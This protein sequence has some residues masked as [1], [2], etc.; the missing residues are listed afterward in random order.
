MFACTKQQGTCIRDTGEINLGNFGLW[1]DRS[2][3]GYFAMHSIPN[4]AGLKYI[5]LCALLKHGLS[6]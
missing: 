4:V 5:W 3:N 2:L 1:Q 6:V